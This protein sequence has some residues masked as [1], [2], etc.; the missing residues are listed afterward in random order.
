ME[1]DGSFNVEVPADIPIEIQLLDENGMAL[2]SCGWI[3]VKNN[4]PRG[5]IGCHEDQELTPENRM[6]DA[7]K[8]PSI[9]LTLPPERRRHRGLPARGDAHRRGQVCLLSRSRA[10]RRDWMAGWSLS[11]TAAMLTSTALTKACWP[12]T[13]RRGSIAPPSAATYMQ[14]GHGPAHLSGISSARTLPAP[15]TFAPRPVRR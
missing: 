4:E 13:S 9:P 7:V 12:R 3:W 8:R 15:G 14:D 6:V 1:E 2:R 5:C 10:R 11:I